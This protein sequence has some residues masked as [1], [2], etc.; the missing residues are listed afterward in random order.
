MDVHTVAAIAKEAERRYGHK[1]YVVQDAAHSYGARWNGELVTAFGDAAI[2]GSNISKIVTSVF[3]GMATT[4][5]EET[6]RHLMEF[7]ER[8]MV[9][10]GGK[11]WKRTLYFLFAN[12]AFEPH[13]YTLVNRLERSGVLD[14]FVKYYDEDRIDFPGD[15]NSLPV[16]IEARV[17][18]SQLRRYEETVA[19]RRKYASFYHERLGG[20]NSLKLYADVPGATYSQIIART[21][22]KKMLMECCIQ[23]GVQLGEVLEYAIPQMSAYRKRYGVDPEK[24]P[25]A[26]QNASSVVNLPV[27]GRWNPDSAEKVVASLKRCLP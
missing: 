2:F 13:V 18:R 20:E 24:F 26:V 11:G 7:R 25:N 10:A 1:V 12:L 21:A 17:G 14:A 19:A 3:G 22:D 9:P 4:R 27:S 15:W 6:Y 23:R 5:S 8:E 16:E